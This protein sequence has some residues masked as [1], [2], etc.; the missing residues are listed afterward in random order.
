M[1]RQFQA[2][3]PGQ[4]GHEPVRQPPHVLGEHLHDR[5]RRAPGWPEETD[6]ARAPLDKRRHVGL[7]GADEQVAFPMPGNDA[8]LNRG[9]PLANRDRPDD[10]PT[11]LRRRGAWPLQRVPL[12]QL[13]LQRFLEHA[14]ALD[15]YGLGFQALCCNCL[16][17]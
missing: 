10:V 11:G 16:L 5:A 1:G 12:A 2:A 9:G 6:V 14:A 17:S 7:P 8:V 13:R 15:G 3:I 4:R